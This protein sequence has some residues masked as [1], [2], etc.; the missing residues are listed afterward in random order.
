VKRRCLEARGAQP[1][2]VAAFALAAVGLPFAPTAGAVP[3]PWK[4]CGKAGDLLSISKAAATYWPPVG[5]PVPLSVVA[6]LDPSGATVVNLEARLSLGLDWV[7]DSG[8]VSF[9]VAAG[10]A[11][12]PSSVPMTLVSPGFPIHAGPLN[13]LETFNSTNPPMTIA[14]QGTLGQTINSGAGTLGLQFNGTSGFPV[15][16]GSGTYEANLQL[17]TLSGQEVFCVDFTLTDT[18]FASAASAAIPTLSTGGLTA[19]ASLLALVGL[20]ALGRRRF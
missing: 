13:L 17:S 7:F 20:L 15:P 5:A 2:L 3:I 16:P 11:T 10:F 19:L 14:T 12:L 4:N 18:A 9:P 6:A 1:C 8:S